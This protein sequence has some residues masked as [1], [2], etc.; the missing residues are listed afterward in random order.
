MSILRESFLQRGDAFFVL[1][2]CS[3]GDAQPLRQIVAA[4][5][6]HDNL[7]G[8]QF[9]KH[10]RT[11]AHIGEDKIPSAWI[12][13]QFHRAKFVL[14]ISAA[15]I[16]HLFGLAQMS[17]ISES[18]KGTGLPNSIHIERLSGFLKNFYQLGS[19]DSVT[20]A[21]TCQAMDFRKR[22]QNDNIST[23]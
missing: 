6:A 13:F 18:G 21:Q 17:V 22:A 19:R 1:L 23:A 12:K 2:H 5:W 8:Q 9:F 10:R 4:Q 20:D 16:D 14:E 15:D 11:V 7:H 3:Y